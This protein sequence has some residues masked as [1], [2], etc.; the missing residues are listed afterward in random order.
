M[1]NSNNVFT[2]PAAVSRPHDDGFG[3]V[4]S[5]PVV[6]STVDTFARRIPWWAWLGFG[7]LFGSGVGLRVTKRWLGFGTV[8]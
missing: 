2:H 7:L 4:P 5:F 6:A 3:V 1:D 8:T